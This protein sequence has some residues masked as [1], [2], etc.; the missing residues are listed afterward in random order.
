[1]MRL[2]SGIPLYLYVYQRCGLIQGISGVVLAT[3][4]QKEDDHLAQHAISMGCKVF[5]GSLEDVLGRFIVCAREDRAE[6]IIRVCGDSPFLDVQ[7]IGR[8][9]EHFHANKLDYVGWDHQSCIPGL[10]SEII[11]LNVLEKIYNSS[12]SREEMEHVTLRIR[13][14]LR[15]YRSEMYCWDQMQE[16]FRG[17]RLTVDT[18]ADWERVSWLARI[19][20]ERGTALRFSS[21][22]VAKVITQ[23][24]SPGSIG[25]SR[26]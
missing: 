13:K 7:W 18:R 2:V 4:S 14:N 11:R 5:R 26:G 20:G 25:I 12:P 6:S 19:L 15:D 21:G 24:A 9:I 8:M 17:V 16:E 3:S 10:D 1:M 23:V 22:D